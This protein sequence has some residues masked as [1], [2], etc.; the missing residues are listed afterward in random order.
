MNTLYINTSNEE[1]QK[2]YTGEKIDESRNL[3]RGLSVSI[4]QNLN[5]EELV[6]VIVVERLETNMS[7]AIYKSKIVLRKK[8]IEK[9]IKEAKCINHF[10]RMLQTAAS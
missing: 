8:S 2:F 3:F 4:H 10:F 7:P 9:K 5:S 1:I 6:D